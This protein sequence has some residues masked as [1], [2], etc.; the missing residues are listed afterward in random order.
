MVSAVRA[1][2]MGEG[3]TLVERRE[4]RERG[5]ERERERQTDRGG[6]IYDYTLSGY[7]YYVTVDMCTYFT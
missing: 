4:L 6:R 5:E 1:Y 3:G 7:I 2:R